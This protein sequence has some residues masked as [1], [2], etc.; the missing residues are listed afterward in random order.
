M[1]AAF[2]NS[3]GFGG[4]NATAAFLSPTVTASMLEK[5]WGREAMNGWRSR[6]EAIAAAGE[7]YDDAMLEQ[8]LEPIYRFGEGV[9]EGADL[10]I[11]ASSIRLPGFGQ[12]V[13]L[14]LDNPY[15]DMTG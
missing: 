13:N 8:T 14:A 5:R 2:V 4:N 10:T 7:R 12:A 6:N 9:L 3:K 11:D 1:K 15:A